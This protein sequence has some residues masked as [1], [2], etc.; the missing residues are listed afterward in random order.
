MIKTKKI[1][2]L[3]FF[4]S[5][6]FISCINTTTK[7]ISPQPSTFTVTLPLPLTATA[8]E[9]PSPTLS[10]TAFPTLPTIPPQ[11]A[12]ALLLEMLNP[13][14]GGCELPCWLNITPGIST[15]ADAYLTWASFLTLLGT[16]KT[17]PRDFS[18]YFKYSENGE[19]FSVVTRY[20]LQP[21]GDV[22]DSMY[23]T[24]QTLTTAENGNR[25]EAFKS[26]IYKKI[27][28]GYSLSNV[29]TKYGQPDQILLSMEIIEAEPTSP[30][31]FRI[32]LLYPALGSIIQYW[33]NAEVED[34][35][36]YGC[37]SDTFVQ[38]WLSSPNS[39][40]RFT[41]TLNQEIW[42]ASSPYFKSPED[43][44]GMTQE[45]FF[46]KFKETNSSCLESS[47]DIWLPQ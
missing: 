20:Y 28:D 27:L 15:H 40:N 13:S 22:I 37:P 43:A 19:D 16:T 36:I 24:T 23:I 35:I 11:D 12:Y 42:S 39:N 26:T 8:T 38:L 25:V 10:P 46:N 14:A 31:Y 30:D 9:T 44:L 5:F 21:T 4:V 41:E 1:V 29:L 47:L 6:V 17:E 7:D 45:E 33:G 2:L 3:W 32:W 34:G 18:Y